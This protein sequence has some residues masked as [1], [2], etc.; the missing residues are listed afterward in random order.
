[1]FRAHIISTE[2]PYKTAKRMCS[3][4]QWEESTSKTLVVSGPPQIPNRSVHTRL[5]DSVGQFR[6]S[7]SRNCASPGFNEAL[8]DLC[9]LIRSTFNSQ[10]HVVKYTSISGNEI[11]FF[12]FFLQD[13]MKKKVLEKKRKGIGNCLDA[14]R[15]QLKSEELN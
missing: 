11:E 2:V 6:A 8:H 3:P 1:V 10:K 9:K 5:W 14:E 12:F 13:Y 15:E 4:C 7:N